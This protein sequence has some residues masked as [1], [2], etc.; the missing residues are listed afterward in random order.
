MAPVLQYTM[1]ADTPNEIDIHAVLYALQSQIDELQNQNM[2]LKRQLQDNKESQRSSENDREYLQKKIASLQQ[3]T[4]NYS[5]IQERL[6]TEIYT[7]EQAMA[8][9]QKENLQLTKAKKDTEK[10]MAFELQTFETERVRWQQREADF[11]NQIRSLNAQQAEP[12]TPKRKTVA[13]PTESPLLTQRAV[14]AKEEVPPATSTPSPRLQTIDSKYSREAKAAQRM[15]KSQDKIITDL[16]RDAENSQTMI[17]EQALQVRAQL[18][19]LEHLEQEVSS[20]KHLNRSLMEENESYQILLHEK[21]ISGEFMMDPILQVDQEA[22]GVQDKRRSMN[23]SSS[24]ASSNSLN[25]AAELNLVSVGTTDWEAKQA[26]DENT[27]IIQKLTDETK[28][29][30]DT[31]RALQ[32]YMNKILMRIVS[33]KQLEDVLSIDQPKP[34]PAVPLLVTKKSTPTRPPKTSPETISPVRSFSSTLLSRATNRQSRPHTMSYKTEGTTKNLGVE[35]RRHSTSLNTS[36]GP[37]PTPSRSSWSS[38][39]RRMSNVW[40][41]PSL[42]PPEPLEDKHKDL[43]MVSEE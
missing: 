3:E 28:M 8:K 1:T 20:M 6:E 15:V 38:A 36:H 26:T 10:K 27:R 22:D 2:D 29:L 7:H 14:E 31:N 25:L 41:N 33:N 30:Q 35:D 24:T 34:K 23:P 32:L 39:L 12:R 4:V 13:K 5:N 18:S 21:T 42:A 19:K 9:C 40:T 37:Q 16:K 17:Q 43:G 11:Y